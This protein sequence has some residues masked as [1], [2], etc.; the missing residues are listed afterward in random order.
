M[1]H[2]QLR[3]RRRLFASAA[4]ISCALLVVSTGPAQA[5]GASSSGVTVAKKALAPYT[6]HPSVFPVTQKLDKKP[7]AGTKIAFLECGAPVCATFAA[8]LKAPVAALGAKLTVISAGL[9]SSTVQSAA[10][11]ALALHPA[12]VL[13]AGT[14]LS[15]FGT[16][17]SALE[18]AGIPVFGIGVTGGKQYGLTAVSGGQADDIKGGQLMADWVLLHKGPHAN[19][20]FFG[21]PE[22]SFSPYIWTAF[23]AQLK[24]ICPSCTSSLSELSVLTYGSSAPSAVVS[25]LRANPSVNTAVFATEEGAIGLPSALSE[26]G[27]SSVA[28]FGFA[29]TSV[30]LAD[31]RSGKIAGGLGLDLITETWQIMDIIAKS[32]T[33]QKVQASEEGG[34]VEV[35]DKSNVTSAEVQNGWSGY[36]DV[37]KRFAALWK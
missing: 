31:I 28:T 19:V 14:T 9:F 30:N 15:E 3:A 16:T 25:Y 35:L 7:A 18:E 6:G 20:V 2:L 34:V 29:P 32:L 13:V 23:S 5:A 17:L 1:T 36:P 11:A 10:E 22:L 8:Q 21:A 24:K 27:L 26:A 33:H 37:A 12:A 4:V